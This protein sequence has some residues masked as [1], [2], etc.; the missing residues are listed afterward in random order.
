VRE[1]ILN[2][3]IRCIVS[4]LGVL[5]LPFIWTLRLRTRSI[6]AYS[7]AIAVWVVR[8]VLFMIAGLGAWGFGGVDSRQIRVEA[9]AAVF[10]AFSAIPLAEIIARIFGGPLA[11]SVDANVLRQFWYRSRLM[12]ST[13]VIGGLLMA[14]SWMQY[15]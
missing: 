15:R 7:P 12:G 1:Y 3:G 2:P 14:Y 13:L 8:A 11:M 10:I 4:G 9:G 5:C 6:P